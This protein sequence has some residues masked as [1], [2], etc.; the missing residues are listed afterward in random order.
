MLHLFKNFLNNEEAVIAR[1]R[2]Q[3]ERLVVIFFSLLQ[4]IFS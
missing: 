2:Q 3:V 1:N 4:R